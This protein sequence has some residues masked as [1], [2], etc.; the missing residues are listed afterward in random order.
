[1]NSRKK[2]NPSERNLFQL[3]FPCFSKSSVDC[4]E[5][6]LRSFGNEFTEYEYVIENLAI[7]RAPKVL[8]D[9]YQPP[10]KIKT[11]YSRYK[12]NTVEHVA[13][14]IDKRYPPEVTVGPV[15]AVV[16][17][18]L[19]ENNL[20]PTNENRDNKVGR[21][22]LIGYNSGQPKNTFHNNMSSK[23]GRYRPEEDKLISKDNFLKKTLVP[24]VIYRAETPKIQI[25]ADVHRAG[26]GDELPKKEMKIIPT[27]IQET[28]DALKMAR[29]PNLASFPR[30][31]RRS[32]MRS[33]SDTSC[34]KETFCNFVGLHN[35]K[36]ESTEETRS[37]RMNVSFAENTR[38]TFI[39]TPQSRKRSVSP[40]KLNPSTNWFIKNCKR[41]FQSTDTLPNAD[42]A[43]FKVMAME[44]D[45]K[46]ATVELDASKRLI[47]ELGRTGS[48]QQHIIQLLDGK[49]T[50]DNNI[51]KNC[52]VASSSTKSQVPIGLRTSNPNPVRESECISKINS[53]SAVISKKEV[54]AKVE[55]ES[56]IDKQKKLEKEKELLKNQSIKWKIIINK[57]K[58]A[59]KKTVPADKK[60]T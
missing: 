28:I 41:R 13:W 36:E 58:E 54:D 9:S 39:R 45:L 56:A 33:I 12:K 49:N 26:G 15:V 17:A 42:S 23:T 60:T 19:E 53:E 35:S 6:M 24:P 50:A 47:R 16:E 27:E 10:P 29:P 48:N 55:D 8:L 44:C 1:M 4:D 3:C 59:T 20:L 14:S 37:S 52:A 18:P 2:V 38:N 22:N 34:D 43:N 46:V 32:L 5:I 30:K 57:H 40:R 7:R 31:N 21:P 11:K 51:N 25:S